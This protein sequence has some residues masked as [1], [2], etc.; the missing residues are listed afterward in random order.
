M[1]DG[2]RVIVYLLLLITE[3]RSTPLFL[4]AFR[5]ARNLVTRVVRRE[6]CVSEVGQS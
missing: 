5:M 2:S 6:Q 4:Y 1:P 3:S